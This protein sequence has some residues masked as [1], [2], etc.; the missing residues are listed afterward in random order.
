M[1][2]KSR[3]AVSDS[4]DMDRL[5]TYFECCHPVHYAILNHDLEALGHLFSLPEKNNCLP[6]MAG[7]GNGY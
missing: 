1:T 4:V 5:N 6:R 3:A 2:I 7:A